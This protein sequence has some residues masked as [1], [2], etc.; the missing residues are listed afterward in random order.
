MEL[1]P[2]GP[3]DGEGSSDEEWR[4]GQDQGNSGVEAECVDNS[5]EEVLETIGGQV[6]MLQ[7][8]EH[9]H[10]GV[11]KCLAESAPGVSVALLADCVSKN[12][13]VGE[14]ALLRG[15]PSGSQRRV[16]ECEASHDGDE[17]SDGTLQDEEPSPALDTCQ[18]IHAFEDTCGDEACKRGRKDVAGVEDADSLRSLDDTEEESREDGAG[19]VVGHGCKRTDDSPCHHET[20]H[21][22]RWTDAGDDHVTGDLA[23]NSKVFLEAVQTG[24]GDGIAI[25]S[26]KDDLKSQVTLRR[27]TRV[28][29]IA[30][31]IKNLSRKLLMGRILLLVIKG[32]NTS[33]GLLLLRCRHRMGAMRMENS[34]YRVKD[35]AVNESE[36]NDIR[37]WFHKRNGNGK[38]TF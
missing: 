13:I 15:E 7:D 9:P 5:R 10:S 16:G 30:L 31:L 29:A 35:D 2:L 25:E 19:V 14:L 21:V 36:G 4:T 33:H 24:E 12:A 8:N 27:S 1:T 34:Y 23:Q 20:A 3:E 32:V 28:I 11:D 37:R 17:E 22:P 38:G 26:L 6:K 18:S